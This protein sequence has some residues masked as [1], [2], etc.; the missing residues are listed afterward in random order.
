MTK[1]TLFALLLVLAGLGLVLA[2]MAAGWVVVNRGFGTRR[3]MVNDLDIDRSA[4]LLIDQHGV[5]ASGFAAKQ[6]DKQ[7]EV[8]DLDGQA[9]W[10]RVLSAIDELQRTRPK[11]DEPMH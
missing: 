9:V 8:G 11:R 4:K 10:L 3:F 7:A 1:P 6:A 5:E 2:V